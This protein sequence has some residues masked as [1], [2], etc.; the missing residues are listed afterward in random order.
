MYMTP[1]RRLLVALTN[2]QKKGVSPVS[3]SICNW[4]AAGTESM[5]GV[6]VDVAELLSATII[7]SV[8]VGCWLCCACF[9]LHFLSLSLPKNHRYAI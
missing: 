7:V 5:K 2:R 3:L 1:S 4:P 9:H 6:Q 8:A